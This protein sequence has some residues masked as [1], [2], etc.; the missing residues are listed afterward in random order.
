MYEAAL[1]NCALSGFFSASVE[2]R[3]PTSEA[4]LLLPRDLLEKTSCPRRAEAT[5]MG[6][7]AE[8]VVVEASVVVVLCWIRRQCYSSMSGSKRCCW[9]SFHGLMAQEQ[10]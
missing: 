3:G 9:P 8:G 10:E 2:G 6:I 1:G 7:A 5:A 4:A